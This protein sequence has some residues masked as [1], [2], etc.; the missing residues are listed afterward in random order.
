MEE[1]W[2]RKVD[3]LDPD[4]RAII[5]LPLD[6]DYLVI[7]PPGSGKTN[8]LL[9]RA[10]FLHRADI[11]DLIV[12]SFT[13]S[14]KEFIAHGTDN[15][16]F[17]PRRVKTFLGWGSSILAEAGVEFEHGRKFDVMMNDMVAKLEKLDDTT[18]TALRCEAILIDE[19]QD[20]S[21]AEIAVMRRLSSQIFAVGDDNQKIYNKRGGLDSLRGFCVSPDPLKYHYR[22]GHKICRGADAILPGSNMFGTSNYVEKQNPSTFDAVGGLDLKAQVECAAANIEAQ[23]KAYPGAWIGVM[24]YS[25]DTVQTIADHLAATP[26]GDLVHLH[27][28][29]HGYVAM[30]AAKP[31]VVS[32]MHSAK[33]LEFRAA[34]ILGA[35]KIPA[36]APR[37]VAYMGVT[38]AKTSL[39]MYH[40]QPLPGYLDRAVAAAKDKKALPPSLDELFGS[41]P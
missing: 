33:G 19:A 35:D 36:A 40:E 7:G 26:I 3:D 2:W 13:R 17:P 14:L 41:A 28:L 8:L 37:K 15:Y 4:Q 39:L 27:L 34:H 16:A 22:N 21:S 32:T 18:A 31:V 25:R 11:R 6:G 12:I 20:Y 23:L 38:R 24:A 10:T 29:E 5:A 1:T 9:L 30:D